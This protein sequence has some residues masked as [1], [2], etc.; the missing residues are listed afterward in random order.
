MTISFKGVR[1]W[2]GSFLDEV[3]AARAYDAKAVELFGEFARLNFPDEWPAERREALYA[4][5]ADGE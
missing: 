5:C 2:L 1:I 4:C 3:E